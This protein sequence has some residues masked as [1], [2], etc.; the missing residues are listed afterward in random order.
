[1]LFSYPGSTQCVEHIVNFMTPNQRLLTA[2]VAHKMTAV[3]RLRWTTEQQPLQTTQEKLQKTQDKL[4]KFK[5]HQK[6]Y[7]E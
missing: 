1:M 6:A 7:K 3:G 4:T 5:R 2:A